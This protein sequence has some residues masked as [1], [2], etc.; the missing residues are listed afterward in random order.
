ML[1]DAL[2]ALTD[3][4]DLAV[5][6]PITILVFVWLYFLPARRNAAWW[7][8][9]AVL[10]LGVTALLKIFFV[11]C[12]PVAQLHSPSGHARISTLF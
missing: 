4:G 7:A 1:A 3:T 2:V 11:I 9:A 12:P 10:C 5:L 8:G 6:L